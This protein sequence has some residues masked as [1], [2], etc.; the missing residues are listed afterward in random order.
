MYMHYVNNPRITHLWHNKV[1]LYKH[2]AL[3]QKSLKVYPVVA[4]V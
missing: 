3:T 4:I 1:E 2:L